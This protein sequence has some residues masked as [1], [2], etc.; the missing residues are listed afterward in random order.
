[1]LALYTADGRLCG[2]KKATGIVG[3]GKINIISIEVEN[4][5]DYSYG[6]LMVWRN[7]ELTPL[8]AAFSL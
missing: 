4:T 2:V 7:G 6:K 3:T 8:T 1:M 5:G